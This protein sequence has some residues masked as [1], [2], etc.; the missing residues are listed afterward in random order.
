MQTC[1]RF[2]VILSMWGIRMYAIWNLTSCVFFTKCE[3][4]GQNMW[5]IGANFSRAVRNWNIFFTV[6]NLRSV[7][8]AVQQCFR[9]VLILNLYLLL[10]YNYCSVFLDM[11]CTVVIK[12]YKW[13]CSYIY[14]SILQ[15]I[16]VL[17]IIVLVEI[18]LFGLWIKVKFGVSAHVL[19]YP[20]NLT[21]K[22]WS[23][24]NPS[25]GKTQTSLPNYID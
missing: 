24:V 6:W 2:G 13:S 9:Q 10:W 3:I 11:K 22:G 25:S 21:Q 4:L 5:R 23:R 20:R 19:L 7:K 12:W 18:V 8:F 16:V 1:S 17:A 14:V 15:Y